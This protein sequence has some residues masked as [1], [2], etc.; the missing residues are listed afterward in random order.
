MSRWKPLLLKP[1]QESSCQSAAN[2]HYI[3][4]EFIIIQ[5][6]LTMWKD[7]CMLIYISILSY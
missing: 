3:T 2:N 5:Y 1:T 7:T 6:V 4:L